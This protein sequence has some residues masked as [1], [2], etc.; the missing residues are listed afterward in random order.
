VRE[1][2]VLEAIASSLTEMFSTDIIRQRVSGMLRNYDFVSEETLA[3]FKPRL[4]Q[5]PQDVTSRSAT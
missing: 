4:T 1:R 3:Y 5:A 2:S